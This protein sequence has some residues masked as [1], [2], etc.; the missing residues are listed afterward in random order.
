VLERAWVELLQVIARRLRKR[1]Q[2]ADD[3]EPH[4]PADLGSVA[5]RVPGHIAELPAGRNRQDLRD[6]LGREARH[7]LQLQVD[8][9]VLGLEAPAAAGAAA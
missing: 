1:N 5:R 4:A 3:V 6:K 9:G 2:V 7:Q 8:V